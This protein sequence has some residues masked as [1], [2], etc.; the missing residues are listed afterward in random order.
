MAELDYA[1]VIERVTWL[2]S[3][4]G[5]Q[6]LQTRAK[7]RWAPLFQLNDVPKLPDHMTRGLTV[8]MP[9]PRLRDMVD[10]LQSDMASYKTIVTVMAMG[11]DGPP[12]EDDKKAADKIERG[13]TIVRQ[14]FAKGGQLRREMLHQLLVGPFFAAE[15]HVGDPTQAFP[16]SVEFPDVDSLKFPVRGTPFRPDQASR[17]YKQLVREASQR[18]S[19]R[20]RTKHYNETLKLEAGK[21]KWVAIGDD[22]ATESASAA[23]LGGDPKYGQEG[24]FIRYSDGEHVYH[25]AVNDDKTS[26]EVVYCEPNLVGGCDTLVICGSS[27]PYREAKHRLGPA[28]I[29]V[30]QTVLNRNLLTAIRAT[31]GMNAKPDL[32]V[33]MTPEA[34]EAAKEAGMLQQV[35]LAEGVP[36]MVYVAGKAQPW[37]LLPDP[38]L[39]NLAVQWRE[40]EAEYV[41]GWKEPTDPDTVGDARANTYLTA[42]EAIRRRQTDILV[43]GDWLETELL[44]MVLHSIKAM[45]RE[46]R[47]RATDNMALSKGEMVAGTT[48]TLGPED[49]DFDFEV[50]VTTKAQTESEL[51]ARHDYG[52]LKVQDGTGTLEEVIEGEYVDATAQIQ[53]LAIDAGYRLQKATMIAY[54]DA[55]WRDIVK[56][57]AGILLPVAGDALVQESPNSPGGVAPMQPAAINSPM[58]GAAA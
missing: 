1:K 57:E 40:E 33:E 32:T 7:T 50:K 23:N 49:L 48:V 42:V 36:N 47:F 6:D 43:S 55:A 12:N 28:L 9:S 14:T 20:P 13:L 41:A 17:R 27:T 19:K 53:R 52:M 24:E 10:T 15:L 11:K 26:G 46:F 58:G 4:S 39:D 22:R 16:W 18:Y 35:A 3:D 25:I 29:P 8:A 54:A 31:K 38:D 21:W 2:E 30:M 51:R 37:A 5:L 34:F 56:T 44:K 45:G